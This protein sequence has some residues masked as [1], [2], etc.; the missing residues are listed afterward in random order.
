MLYENYDITK[1]E[2]HKERCMQGSMQ[3]YPV[4]SKLVSGYFKIIL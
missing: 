2:P 1:S 3:F 4:A